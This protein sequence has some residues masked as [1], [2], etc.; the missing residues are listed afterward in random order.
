M[1]KVTRYFVRGDAGAGGQEGPFREQGHAV[2]LAMAMARKGARAMVFSVTGEPVSDLWE[3]PRLVRSYGPG[4]M[5][6]GPEPAVRVPENV[7]LLRF[8]RP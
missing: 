6:A 4:A 5:A 8:R 2:G 1:F 3:E 7:I